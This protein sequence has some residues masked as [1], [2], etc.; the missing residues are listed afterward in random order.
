MRLSNNNARELK[1][2]DKLMLIG[3]GPVTKMNNQ[4]RVAQ[5]FA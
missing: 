3:I 2:K 1:T 4:L 5:K